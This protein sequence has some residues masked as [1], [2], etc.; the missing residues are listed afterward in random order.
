[1][2]RRA[3]VQW[4]QLSRMSPRARLRAIKGYRLTRYG[5]VVHILD[6]VESSATRRRFENLP[7]YLGFARE[8]VDVLSRPV[9][10]RGPLADLELRDRV[11]LAHV[12]RHKL[13][14]GAAREAISEAERLARCGRSPRSVGI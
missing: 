10:G 1:E 13:D 9:Y 8:L 7:G 4:A 2:C 14:F 11:T 3:V 5:L 6:Q 12:L